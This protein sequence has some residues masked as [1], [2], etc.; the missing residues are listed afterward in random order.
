MD[1]LKQIENIEVPSSLN[2]GQREAFGTLLR[3]IYD[4]EEMKGINYISLTSG[5]GYGKSYLLGA[6]YNTLPEDIQDKVHFTATTNK[7]SQELQKA[8]LEHGVFVP[9]E[10][11]EDVED[12]KKVT[13][14]YKKLSLTLFGHKKILTRITGRGPCVDEGDILVIDEASFIDEELLSFIVQDTLGKVKVIFVGDK[15]QLCPVGLDYTPIFDGV[16]ENYTKCSLPNGYPVIELTQRMRQTNPNSYIVKYTEELKDYIEG[17][18]EHLPKIE[19]EEG[20]K[21]F[22]FL[23]QKQ[24]E[25]SILETYNSPLTFKVL[26]QTNSKVAKYNALI[27]SNIRDDRYLIAGDIATVNTRTQHY[28]TDE[29]VMVLETREATVPEI[30]VRIKMKG[31]NDKVYSWDMLK[32]RYVKVTNGVKT[33]EYFVP[34]AQ[35]KT[36]EIIDIDT[37]FTTGVADLRAIHSS[38]VH[39][40]QGGTF[41]SVFLDLGS[42]SSNL[43]H[44]DLARLLYVAISRAKEKVYITGFHPDVYYG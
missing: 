42:F 19:F 16:L 12:S 24:F 41:D 40:A 7:A 1:I 20:N 27:N 36:R 10:S 37:K 2:E 29:S 33:S 43:E 30:K 25:V 38:T 35:G 39:K 6:L 11:D 3:F 44:K 4:V 26:A 8:V 9:E 5:P 31:K 32:G 15:N 28:F 18:S 22:Q 13:T 17:R 34:N 23:S 21:E 14:I